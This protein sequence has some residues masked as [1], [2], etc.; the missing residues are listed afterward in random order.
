MEFDELLITTGV[1]ALVRLIKEKQRIELEDAASLLNIPQETL[2]EWARV[3]EEEGILRIEYRLT[4]L[5]LA[6]VKPTEEELSTEKESFYEEKKG[7]EAELEGLSRRVAQGTGGLGEL[8]KSFAEFYARTY[9]KISELEKA[10]APLPAAKAISQDTFVKY[11]E[12]LARN[13][14]LLAETKNALAAVRKEIAGLGISKTA[15]PAGQLLEKT[16][17]MH[18]ELTAMQEE[19]A[20]VRKR[21]AQ[22]ESANAEVQMPSTKDIKKKFETMQKDFTSLRSRNAQLRQDMLSLHESSEI[23]KTVAE[24][25]MGQEDQIKNVHEEIAALTKEAEELADKTTAVV[26]K[27][28]QN[29]ELAERLG[30]SVDVARNVL[31]KFPSQD[32]VMQELDKLKADEDALLEKNRSLS[33]IIEAAGGKQVTAKQMTELTDRMD[34]KVERLR[35]DIDSLAAALED[36]KSTYLTFQKIKE[37]I[38]PAVEGYDK[39]LDSMEERMAK[40]RQESAEQVKSVRADSQKLQES[41]KGGQMQGIVKVAEEIRDKKRML[42]EIKSSL[43]E[44]ATLSDNL[45][46]RITLLSREAKLLEIRSGGGAPVPPAEVTAKEKGIRE[47]I[48]LTEE[49][50]LEFRKKRD[51]LKK[52]IQRL[53][54][55]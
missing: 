15:A 33:Q 17:K 46:K 30:D 53:W 5:Y 32:K 12:E 38:V 37:R 49:E 13:A 45:N 21:A 31:K 18:A 3:L 39:Q 19:M 40:I 28:R 20:A 51:E 50:E 8:E 35:K 29:A 22:R 41:L 4:K 26:D 16:E 24:A 34:D 47:Q 27:V 25:I 52:L 23:L 42:D 43:E 14:A 9:S 55:E 6:W 54:E 11:E 2:E 44:L 1:D 10:V 48:A 36:E 7:V